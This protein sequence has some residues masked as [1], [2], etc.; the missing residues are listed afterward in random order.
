MGRDLGA[1]DILPMG[2]QLAG[3][4]ALALERIGDATSDERGERLW[5]GRLVHRAG[6]CH[7][8]EHDPNRQDRREKGQARRQAE[9]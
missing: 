8:V 1:D 9:K 6:L 4:E 7:M 3:R 2:D 5:D